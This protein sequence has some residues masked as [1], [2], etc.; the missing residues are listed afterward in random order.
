MVLAAAWYWQPQVVPLL[1]MSRS[2]VSRM[3]RDPALLERL[4]HVK[5]TIDI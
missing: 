5:Y 1:V 2:R 4:K 3:H